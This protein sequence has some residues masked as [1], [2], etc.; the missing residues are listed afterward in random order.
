MSDTARIYRVYKVLGKVCYYLL[1]PFLYVIGYFYK[2]PRTRLLLI[3]D[4]KA[5]LVKNWLGEQ[6]WTLPGGGKKYTE[7]EPTA[8][9]REVYEE[10]GI[11]VDSAAFT[12]FDKMRVR[13]LAP[14]TISIYVLEIR[15]LP[16]SLTLDKKEIIAAMW[17]PLAHLPADSSSELKEIV[18]RYSQ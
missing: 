17:C 15:T 2:T 1:V 10:L 12:Y 18:T 6:T 4:N 7:N 5:L 14:Y 8:L 9:V 13:R 11:S 3:H 16:V